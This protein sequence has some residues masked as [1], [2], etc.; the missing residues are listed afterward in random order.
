MAKRKRE[1]GSITQ[2]G[3]SFL[4]RVYAGTDPITGKRI[5]LTGTAHSPAEAEKLR[6]KLLAQV[7]ENRHPK[8][9]ATIGQILDRYMAVNRVDDST[10]ER[11]EE[12]IRLYLKPAFG[13]L[14]A[15]KLTAEMIELFYARLQRCKEQCEGK[16]D[17]K[18]GHRCQPLAPAS[19]RKMHFILRPAL[20]RAVRWD[21]VTVNV[22]AMA[23]P[24]K[25]PPANP[26]PPTAA[27]A[28][29]ILN[30]AWTIDP[31]WATFL[32]LAMVTGCRRGEL[33][34]LQ[35]TSVDFAAQILHVGFSEQQLRQRRR[36][37]KKTKTH[38]DRRISFDQHTAE[39]L[40]E[41]RRRA[42]QR[43]AALGF[44]LKP[45]AYLF[46][47][48]PDGSVPFYPNNVS[49]RYGR[50]ATKLELSTRRLHSLRHYSATELIAA[51]VD[52]RTVA[53]RLGHGSGGATTLKVY[54]AWSP[55]ADER[56]ATLLA[57]RLPRPGRDIVEQTAMLVNGKAL[58]CL[59][60]N[61]TSWA[62]LRADGARVTA[63]CGPCGAHVYGVDP[64]NGEDGQE[65]AY[66]IEQSPYKR[67]AA[68]L[69]RQIAGGQ[70][71]HGD[72]L[73]SVADLAA[74]HGVSVGTAHRA[75]ALLT[76]EGLVSVRRGVR[77]TV[78][79]PESEPESDS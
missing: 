40:Q 10:V 48:E 29:R 12:L 7:D 64:T 61:A 52:L 51:G 4:V 23:E 67:L 2:R 58:S 60:G 9:N 73:P 69:R 62:M 42:E 31:D 68:N 53:G 15:S 22:A 27:E 41:L 1:R 19:V 55:S 54:A 76:K 43:C 63:T 21:Y 26:D 56:A 17:G 38:R 47:I 20:D 45:T 33:I 13:K 79:A 39:L 72:P 57:N 77:A 71:A 24:P 36:R 78:R 6:T 14:K 32:W 65:D 16:R 28:A 34:G 11:Y 70:L 5:D 66:E 46:S 59:C 44:E 3:D 25:V 74:S 35:W 37:R 8:K 30:R 50:L 75:L 49:H 18:D